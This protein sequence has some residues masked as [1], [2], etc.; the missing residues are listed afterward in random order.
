ME[1]YRCHMC[2]DTGYWRVIGWTKVV[3][4]C[5]V[6]RFAPHPDVPSQHSPS[7]A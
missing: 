6:H 3:W 5:D 1:T 7:R 4:R 2:S